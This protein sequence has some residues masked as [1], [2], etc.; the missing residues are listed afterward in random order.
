VSTPAVPT[1]IV[2]DRSRPPYTVSAPLVIMTAWV[3]TTGTKASTVSSNQSATYAHAGDAT[4]VSTSATAL[5]HLDSGR[6]PR[7]T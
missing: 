1:A 4:Y 6:T 7:S 5:P 2:V 3:G